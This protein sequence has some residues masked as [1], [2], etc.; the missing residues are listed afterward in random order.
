MKPTYR[1]DT[2]HRQAIQDLADNKKMPIF[3]TMKMN[4]ELPCNM[5]E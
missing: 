4:D 3:Y 2:A 5:H 1:I